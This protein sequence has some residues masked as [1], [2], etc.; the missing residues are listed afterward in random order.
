MEALDGAAG[1]QDKL[2]LEFADGLRA[3]AK[4]VDDGRNDVDFGET[5]A[6]RPRRRPGTPPTGRSKSSKAPRP[7]K[8]GTSPNSKRPCTRSS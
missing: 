6:A 8:N 4:F 1:A 3:I 5:P 7:R 2:D